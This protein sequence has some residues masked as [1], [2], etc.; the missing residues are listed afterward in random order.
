MV[1]FDRIIVSV[2]FLMEELI[3]DLFI[4]ILV[5]VYEFNIERFSE[6]GRSGVSGWLLIIIFFW[7]GNIYREV[8]LFWNCW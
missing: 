8:I 5:W 3:V 4:K 2:Y 6:K 7:K 1:E